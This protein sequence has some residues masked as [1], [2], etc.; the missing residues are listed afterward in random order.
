MTQEV[1]RVMNEVNTAEGANAQSAGQPS[2][3]D[4]VRA[5]D[6]F[7]DEVAKLKVTGGGC[8]PRTAGRQ[9][10]HRSHDL[11]LCRRVHLV[12]ERVQCR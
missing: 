10:G 4:V 3:D 8:Q 2:A 12:V 5:L 7:E 1:M 9:M 11:R 6:Q